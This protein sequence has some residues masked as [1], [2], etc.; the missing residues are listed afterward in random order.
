MEGSSN[1]HEAERKFAL[2]HWSAF[3]D[4]E[5]TPAESARIEALLDRDPEAAA[6]IACH[7]EIDASLRDNLVHA[8]PPCPEGLRARVLAALDRCEEPAQAQTLVRLPWLS[9]GAL[10]AASVMMAASLFLVF[11]P[12]EQQPDP[13]DALKLR[14]TPV[15]SS[16]SLEVPKSDR[17][18]YR[19][20][21]AQYR[22]YFEDGPDLPASFGDG[23]CRVSHFDCPEV[24]GR[25]VACAVYDET[26]GDRFALIVF[27]CRRT[28]DLLPDFL[29]A[30]ELEI[31][32]RHV[33]LW[34]EGNYVR[35]LVG[36]GPAHPLRS[37]AARLRPAA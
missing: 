29:D 12:R 33:L 36:V 13:A 11:G 8:A 5:L 14:L 9:V 23:Q 30:A 21:T 26:N 16:V 20:A 32:G 17:C 25:R 24:N 3:L 34:R 1:Q 6:L 28:A 35:A 37:R 4:G 18:R 31:D 22:Q 15:V 7:R 2:E 27:R 19:D 10:A